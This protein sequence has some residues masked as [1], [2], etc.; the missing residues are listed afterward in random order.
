MRRACLLI[1]SLAA[2]G[3]EPW[4]PLP[5]GRLSGEVAPNPPSDWS[6]A[7]EY[8]IVQIETRPSD[9]Y[10]VNLWGA[11]VGESFFV[12]AG[13]GETADWA[14]HLVDDPNVRLRVGETIYELRAVRIQDE[15]EVARFMTALV[16]KYEF[17]PT[18]EQRRE[19][20]LFRLDPR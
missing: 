13:E 16:R 11:G 15:A 18:E 6:L 4:G 10:S 20:W 14:Q 1:L 17:E 2:F 19:A 5:G 8:E 3:C 9:P 12:A 7:D